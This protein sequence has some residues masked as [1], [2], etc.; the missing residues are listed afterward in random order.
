MLL[1][2][3]LFGQIQDGW[4]G[5]DPD[6]LQPVIMDPTRQEWKNIESNNGG[7]VRGLLFGDGSLL[8]FNPDIIHSQVINRFIDKIE[9]L[10]K[11]MF[12]MVFNKGVVS[13]IKPDEDHLQLMYDRYKF[14][15]QAASMSQL[16]TFQPATA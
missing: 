4:K 11:P 7:Y 6:Q 9:T 8:I 1:T 15:S 2:E 14:L 12:K 16:R 5:R 13:G 10:P 3:L